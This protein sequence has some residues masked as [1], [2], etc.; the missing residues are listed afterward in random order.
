MCDCSTTD[1]SGDALRGVEV[2]YCYLSFDIEAH[3]AVGTELNGSDRTRPRWHEEFLDSVSA[4]DVDLT[5]AEPGI[6]R[7][8][9]KERLDWI[10]R[11]AAIE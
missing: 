3:E 1:A 9:S 8:N 2:P 6:I 4:K 11:E 7:A 5:F 10:I